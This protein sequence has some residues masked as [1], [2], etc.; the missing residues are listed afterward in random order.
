MIHQVVAGENPARNLD[1]SKALSDQH[2]ADRL[3]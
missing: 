2:R 3:L 1:Q